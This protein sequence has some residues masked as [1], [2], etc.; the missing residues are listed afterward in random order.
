M[1]ICFISPFCHGYFT[2][3]GFGGAEL[4]VVELASMFARHGHDVTIITAPFSAADA[5]GRIP[6]GVKIKKTPFR[7]YGGSNFFFLP[8]SL[9]LIFMLWKENADFYFLKIPD[10]LLFQI[11]LMRFLRPHAKVFKLFASMVETEKRPGLVNKLH[12]MG[13][14]LAHGFVFQT[15]QQEREAGKNWGIRG[16][17]IRNI[18][19]PP[20]IKDVSAKDIDLLWVG[21][22]NQ[23]KAPEK[24]LELAKSMP[25]KT[26]TVISKPCTPE[27]AALESELKSL[28]NVEY[29]GTIPS[30]KIG[31]YYART[32]VLICTSVVE[33]FPNTFLNAW[34]FKA[35]VISLTFACDDLLT[36]KNIGYV[37]ESIEQM[38]EDISRLLADHELRQSMGDNGYAYVQNNHLAEQVYAK[39]EQLVLR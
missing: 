4:Q 21:A 38:K 26:F 10:D 8:D 14:R 36:E 3:C 33:G 2:G 29:L 35:P 5:E 18:F 23:W 13:V 20:E 32:K 11:G 37:S 6:D 22:F 30:G 1:K 12:A 28:P 15:R 24:L 16:V 17:L 19:S 39:Y 7:F 34:F 25:E 9:R 27:Y 31:N